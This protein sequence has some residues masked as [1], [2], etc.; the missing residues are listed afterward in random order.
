ML[1]HDAEDEVSPSMKSISLGVEESLF[2]KWGEDVPQT[3]KEKKAP[4]CKFTEYKEL[5]RYFNRDKKW[6]ASTMFS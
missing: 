4:K 2:D 3:L 6:V 1:D 5:S